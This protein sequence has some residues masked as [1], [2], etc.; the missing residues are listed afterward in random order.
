MT[1]AAIT[2]ETHPDWGHVPPHRYHVMVCCG[3]RCVEKGVKTLLKALMQRAKDR[4]II[5]VDG[6]VLVTRTHC[7]YPCNLGPIMTVYPD[8]VWYRIQTVQDIER[9]VDEHFVGGVVC[10]DLMVREGLGKHDAS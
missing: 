9:I 6:G 1:Q 7:Q 3:P 5:E 2:F 10:R 8:G 4:G